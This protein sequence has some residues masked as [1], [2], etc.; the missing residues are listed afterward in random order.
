MKYKSEIEMCKDLTMIISGMIAP[1]KHKFIPEVPRSS[2]NNHSDML[3]IR[4]NGL[5]LA[6][7]HFNDAMNE[8]GKEKL[9]YQRNISQID[10]GL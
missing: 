3:F 8:I 7:K 10:I 5:I 4:K 6:R 2:G 1:A 9:K